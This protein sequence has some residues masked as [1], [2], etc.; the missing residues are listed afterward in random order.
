MLF[1][2]CS[3]LLLQQPF[4]ISE[5]S[6]LKVKCWSPVADNYVALKASIHYVSTGIKY[7]Y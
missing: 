4:N 5:L 3:I 6:V 2:L 1:C 7:M